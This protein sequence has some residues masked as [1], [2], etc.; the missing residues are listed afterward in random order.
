MG[1]QF[2][3]DS[4]AALATGLST[5]HEWLDW[6][7]DPQP[8]ARDFSPELAWMPAGLRRRV[9][10][11][12]RAALNVLASCQLADAAPVVFASRY[13]DLD[14]IAGLLAQLDQE[15]VLSPMGFSLSVHNAA[16]GVHSI[17]R[18]DRTTTT[19]IAVNEDLAEAACFEALGWLGAGTGQVLMVCCADPVPPPYEPTRGAETY[20]YAWACRLRAVSSGGLSLSP[21]NGRE[22]L[23]SL[24]PITPPS[25]QALSF[26]VGVH[27]GDLRSESGRYL[28]RRHV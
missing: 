10:P 4:W 14:G 12:G 1:L 8:L 16:M 5:Q 3:V 23:H 7:R 25:L 18:K 26:L 21:A 17:A 6:L 15:G 22:K 27:P 2:T 28:W 13:G 20:R 24:N 11:L 9:S 19:C